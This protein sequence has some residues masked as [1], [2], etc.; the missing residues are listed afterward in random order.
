MSIYAIMYT[1]EGRHELTYK[2][3]C[4]FNINKLH[5]EDGPAIEY[6][7]GHKEW[8]LHDKRHREDGPALEFASGDR[9]WYL[10]GKLHRED[11]PAI[12]YVGG[13]R[14]WYLNGVEYIEEVY[15]RELN[16]S[17]ILRML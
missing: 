9:E 16:K 14:E 5:R 7:N 2:E 12:E 10:H 15:N 1:K 13:Y 4:K 8:W 11:G 3:W 17:N 6:V